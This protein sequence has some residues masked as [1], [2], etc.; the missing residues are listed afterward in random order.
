MTDP[1][2]KIDYKEPEIS[3]PSTQR[4]ENIWGG[5]STTS[6]VPTHVPKTLQEQLVIYVNG[7]TLRLYV[8]DIINNTWRYTALT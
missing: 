8:Y 5:L 7:A 6:S 4:L 1:L 2:L 3:S